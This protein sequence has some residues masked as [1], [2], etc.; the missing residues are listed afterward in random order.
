M[1]QASQYGPRIVHSRR[2]SLSMMNV[3]LRVATV[4]SVFGIVPPRTSWGTYWACRIRDRAAAGNSSLRRLPVSDRGSAGE[5]LPRLEQRLQAAE[6]V[7][8][9]AGDALR[10][11]RR[12]LELVVDDRQLRDPAVLRLDLPRHPAGLLGGHVGVVGRDEAV[13]ELPRGIGLE[14]LLVPLHLS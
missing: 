3:P 2:T 14:H 9:A 5:R 11:L 12:A 1:G 7:H 10:R 4:K 8:P 13:D 6:D